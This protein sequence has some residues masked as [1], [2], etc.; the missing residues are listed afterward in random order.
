MMHVL[1]MIGK[2]GH[3]RIH[4]LLQSMG[5]SLSDCIKSNLTNSDELAVHI[6]FDVIDCSRLSN[7][8]L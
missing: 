8:R 1:V 6:T 3:L 4:L 2:T 5:N 7:S